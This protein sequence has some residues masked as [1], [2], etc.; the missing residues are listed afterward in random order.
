MKKILILILS[1]HA[2]IYASF[3]EFKF[4]KVTEDI[5]C[6]I[7]DFNPVLKSNQGFVSNVCYVDIGDTLVLLDAGATYNFAKEL[8]EA[9]EAKTSKKIGYVVVTNY[10]DD[11]LLGTSYFKE[12]NVKIIGSSNLP[13]IMK[14]HSSKYGRVLD[15]LQKDLIANTKVTN[16]DILVKE[17]YE[18]KGSKK[19][20]YVLKLSEGSQSATDLIVHSPKDSFAFTGNMIFNGRF[21]NYASDSN[22]DGWIEALTSLKSM[23]LKYIMGGHGNEFDAHSYKLTLEYLKMLKKQV[24][25]AYEKDIDP[26]DLSKNIHTDK[27]ISV[28][29]YDTLYLRNARNYFDQLEW[30]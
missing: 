14:E 27:F 11:R 22:M 7:G 8:N 12:K 23:N 16:P 13:E 3:F 24:K 6:V 19:S 20:I 30:M 18:I 15:N 25:S 10:H 28:P 26:A 17:K 5:G 29:H 21:I 4:V 9:I 1:L 2:F